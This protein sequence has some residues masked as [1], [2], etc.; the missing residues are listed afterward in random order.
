M[1]RTTCCVH[2]GIPWC[3]KEIKDGFQDDHP[4]LKE[5]TPKKANEEWDVIRIL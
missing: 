2:K 1:G 3:K 4:S 5:K